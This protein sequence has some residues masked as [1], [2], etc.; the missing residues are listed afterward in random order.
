[1]KPQLYWAVTRRPRIRPL[2]THHLVTLGDGVVTATTAN[3]YV[4]VTPEDVA[5][6]LHAR[7]APRVT[8]TSRL[9]PPAP[10]PEADARRRVFQGS[11]RAAGA[12]GPPT[13][14]GSVFLLLTHISCVNLF[15]RFSLQMNNSIR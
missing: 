4:S 7:A 12:P 10:V 13:A 6:A 9:S 3:T 2:W 11:L 8:P 5:P 14:V 15:D 1:M